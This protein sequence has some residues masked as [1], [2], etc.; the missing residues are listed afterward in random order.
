[1]MKN[2]KLLIIFV[3]A[4][5]II[6]CEDK[7]ELEPRQSVSEGVAT[8]T[9]A[10][11]QSILVGAYASARGNYGGGLNISS[12]ILGNNNH[13]NWNGTFATW[14]EMFNKAMTSTNGQVGAMYATAYNVTGDVNTVLANLNKFTVAADKNR[15]EG[16]AKFLRAL[17]LFDLV[18]LFGKPYEA[19]AANS[20]LGVTIVTV[21]PSIDIKLPRNTVAEC[22]TQI[23]ADL[24]DA[25]AKLPATNGVYAD[26]YTA[27]A[28]L[29]RVYLQ[30]QDYANARDAAHDVIANSGH[31]LVTSS[32]AN[33]FDTDTSNSEFIHSWVVTQQEGTNLSVTHYATQALGGRGGDISVHPNYIAKFD[34][35]LDE[36]KAHFYTSGGE[37]L[38]SKYRRQFANTQMI[39]LAEMYL[40]R[41]EANFRATTTVGATPLADVNT[42]RA[43]SKAPALGAIT[44][45][46]ILN[47]RELELGF[48][49]FFLHDA[50][51][52][53][54]NVGALPYNDDKLV[55]PIPRAAMD[56][57]DLLVQNPGYSS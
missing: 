2:I 17:S 34:S 9:A 54:A 8:S 36:R 20:Q 14:R 5:L 39:R 30:M 55:M 13:L 38:V 31:S 47:E 16:E 49:G 43:R 3:F 10:N 7:L 52:T 22:Y 6:S 40:I 33:V 11:I 32:Y 28:I 51:R 23:L 53:K 27:K 45:P 37:T 26:K 42:V 18:R 57:N 21:P 41:A 12:D 56:S 15:V 50:K 4:G 19:G 35:N 44:L 46:L 29:A 1:M 24:N 25:Y 48:E